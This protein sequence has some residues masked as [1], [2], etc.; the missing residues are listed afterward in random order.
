M[1]VGAVRIGDSEFAV[2][3]Q[4]CTNH[5]SSCFWVLTLIE[6]IVVGRSTAK[7]SC[8]SFG[9]AGGRPSVGRDVLIIF[10][11]LTFYFCVRSLDRSLATKYA[12]VLRCRHGDRYI[13]AVLC[14][15]CSWQ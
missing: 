12:G 2:M 8:T 13:R 1:L 6:E 10:L 11:I 9:I 4:R 5:S 14:R 15:S 7:R 3:F